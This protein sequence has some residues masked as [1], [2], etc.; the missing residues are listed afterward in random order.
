MNNIS[1]VPTVLTA[2]TVPANLT[3][4][5]VPNPVSAKA[6]LLLKTSSK[7]P[8]EIMVI[9][10]LGKIHRK[11]SFK[12]SKARSLDFSVNELPSGHYFIIIRQGDEM[13]TARFIVK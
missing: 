4:S 8:V 1:V 12:N 11:L 5:V 6:K 13:A 2:T 7:L 9:D 3:A 10:I